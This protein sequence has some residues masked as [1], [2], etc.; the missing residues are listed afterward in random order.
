MATVPHIPY[1]AALNVPEKRKR[2]GGWAKTAA[3]NESKNIALNGCSLRS[4]S[5][6]IRHLH[7]PISMNQSQDTT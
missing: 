7:P 3:I 1:R 2:K 4:E 6:V 5:S